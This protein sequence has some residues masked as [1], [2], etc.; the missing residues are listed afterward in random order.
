MFDITAFIWQAAHLLCEVAERGEDEDAHEDEEQE[1]TQLL[2]A[3]SEC[4][5]ECLDGR[6]R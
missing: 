6:R 4:E 3:V 1:E 2:A 5:G